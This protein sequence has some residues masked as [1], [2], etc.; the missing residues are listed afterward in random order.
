MNFVK[1]NS[2]LHSV[3]TYDFVYRKNDHADM[4]VTIQ[5]KD[6]NSSVIASLTAFATSQSLR[7]NSCKSITPGYTLVLLLLS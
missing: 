3:T 6:Y 4:F 7:L 2:C 5:E 1:E